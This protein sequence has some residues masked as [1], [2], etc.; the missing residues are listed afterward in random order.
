MTAEEIKTK[1]LELQNKPNRDASDDEELQKLYAIRPTKEK[2][3]EPKV[4]AKP[5]KKSIAQKIKDVVKR[6]K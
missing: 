1:T 6:N 5:K 2:V 4:E 3:V